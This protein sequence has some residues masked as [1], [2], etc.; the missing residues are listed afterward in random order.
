[1]TQTI[2]PAGYRLT[3]TSWENDADNYNTKVV[4]GLSKEEC[5]FQAD[6]C[7]ALKHSTDY[8]NRICNFYEPSDVEVARLVKVWID[9]LQKYNLNPDS[10]DMNETLNTLG[11]GCSGDFYTRVCE[12]YK[13]EYTPIDI[14]FEDVSEQF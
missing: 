11:L 7:K 6:F 13:V 1:M 8:K 4:E 12:S 2:I 5:Q 14:V 10:Y 9:L 3:V